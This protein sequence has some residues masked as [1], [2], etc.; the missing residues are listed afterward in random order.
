MGDSFRGMCRADNWAAGWAQQEKEERRDDA[1]P[2][3]I[4]REKRTAAAVEEEEG[5]MGLR[6]NANASFTRIPNSHPPSLLIFP[7]LP[8][9][10]HKNLLT[11]LPSIPPPPFIPLQLNWPIRGRR[12]FL[13]S[14][15][16]IEICGLVRNMYRVPLPIANCKGD[17]VRI[18]FSSLEC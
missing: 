10:L 2:R 6:G 4:K 8:S 17:Y 5:R 3:A 16:D 7:P 1:Q 11:F 15:K 14:P 12:H 9:I 13:S 18:H